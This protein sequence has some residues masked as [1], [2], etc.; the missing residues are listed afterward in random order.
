MKHNEV[1]GDINENGTFAGIRLS[2]KTVNE[3][4]RYQIDND[5]QNPTQSHKLH[6]TLLY[7]K[8]PCPGYR[9]FGTYNPPIKGTYEALKIFESKPDESG[10]TANCLVMVVDCPELIERQRY[11]VEKHGATFDFDEYIP[12]VTLSYD[13]GDVLVESLPE[14]AYP[15][16]LTYEYQEKIKS[17]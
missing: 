2:Q 17:S 5:V 10:N 1:I 4:K 9:P 12:H 14:F 3:I 16:M 6:I 8:K 7:S 11:L 15:I 13:A